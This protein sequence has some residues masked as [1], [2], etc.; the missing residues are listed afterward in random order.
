MSS[1]VSNNDSVSN[2]YHIITMQSFINS[3]WTYQKVMKVKHS[4]TALTPLTC[5]KLLTLQILLLIR[6]ITSSAI[7]GK[8]KCLFLKG[9]AANII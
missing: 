8:S 9:G 7:N 6:V 1:S 2:N 4:L 5:N 3:K